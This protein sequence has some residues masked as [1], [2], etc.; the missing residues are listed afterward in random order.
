MMG[1]KAA[2]MEKK[3][4][5]SRNKTSRRQFLQLST[6]AAAGLVTSGL[7]SS[8]VFAGHNAKAEINDSTKLAY[9]GGTLPLTTTPVCRN[10]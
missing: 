9:E 2:P 7:A 5:G 4:E 3:T 6:A 1:D 8:A 10:T